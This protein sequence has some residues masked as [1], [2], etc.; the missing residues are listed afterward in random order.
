MDIPTEN[1]SSP[2][3]LPAQRIDAAGDVHIDLRAVFALA[4]PLV[5]NSAIQM[6]LNLT[7]TWFIGRLSTQSVAAVG[8][9][10]WLVIVVIML[11][12]GVGLAV[13]TVVAQSFGARRYSRAS[14]A[15]WLALWGVLLSVPLYFAA[16]AA[17]PWLLQPFELD[18]EVQRL[19]ADFWLPR[20]SGSFLGAATWAVLGFFNG[21]GRP[22]VT[23]AATAVMA[24]SNAILNQIFIFELGWGIGGSGLATSVAQGLG[25]A[26][27]LAVFLAPKYRHRFHSHLTWKLH[28]TRLIKQFVLGF[29]MGLLYAGD[30]IG[31]ALFQI[32]QVKLGPADGAATQIAMML[33]SIAYLPGVG[34]ALAGMTLVG[35]SIGAGDRAWAMKIGTRVTAIAA[36]YMGGTGVLI[37]LSGPWLMP[38]FTG[39]HDAQ[40]L[41]VIALGVK[42][43][44]FA[45]AYQFFDGLYLGSGFCLRGAGDAVVPAALVLVISWL[46]FVPLAH[47]LTFAPGQ[48]WV[49]GLPQLGWGVLGGWTALVFYSF[50]LGLVLLIRWRSGA[51][52]RIQI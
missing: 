15:V 17:G 4:A 40:S 14:Q 26:Y 2:T 37:A 30:L 7:D 50:L 27:V 35:Q 23:L 13:Q 19:A 49:D 41:A 48:G 32:M 34:I 3:C 43:L 36:F 1:R 46:V 16:G 31:A 6:V 22:R 51:W 20:V 42:I 52:R 5:A 12:G 24:V 47:T 11:F 18:A 33:T 29:P 38:L 8:A 21:I 25:L 45:A 10:H 39:A 9:V 44:W 28:R